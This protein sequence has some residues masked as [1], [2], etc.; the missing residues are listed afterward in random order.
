MKLTIEE[1]LIC[2]KYMNVSGKCHCD[3]CPLNLSNTDMYGDNECYA[4]VDG[5]GMN[6]K[7][8]ENIPDGVVSG[9]RA[10]AERAG[11]TMHQMTYNRDEIGVPYYTAGRKLFAF[12]DELDAW[13]QAHEVV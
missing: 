10:I 2:S 6:I 11:I 13:R 9:I 3:E 7:R 8:Y 5:R 1:E 12:V 4:T